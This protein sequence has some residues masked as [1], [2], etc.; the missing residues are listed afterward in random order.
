MKSALDRVAKAAVNF[1]FRFDYEAPFM[2]DRQPLSANVA[3]LTDG[4][5]LCNQRVFARAIGYVGNAYVWAPDKISLDAPCPTGIKDPIVRLPKGFKTDSYNLIR[6]QVQSGV[7]EA[8]NEQ[9]GMVANALAN[10]AQGFGLSAGPGGISE[11]E[12]DDI[13]LTLGGVVVEAT[14]DYFAHAMLGDEI[15]DQ[16]VHM[17]FQSGMNLTGSDGGGIPIQNL[18]EAVVRLP[19]YTYLNAKAAI[20]SAHK[21]NSDVLVYN[22]GIGCGFFAGNYSANVKK[23]N[24]EAVVKALETFQQEGHSLEVIVPNIGYVSDQE[25]RLEALGVRIIPADKDAVAALCAR[26]GLVVSV[27]VAADPMSMLGIHGPGL[28]WETAG[29]ASDEERA[30]YLSPCYGIAHTPILIYEEG[31]EDPIKVAALSEFMVIDPAE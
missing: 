19:Q 23:A 22:I 12:A 26:A 24:V 17:I 3:P 20:E 2:Q 18:R 31:C 1:P 6:R 4:S 14:V 10:V 30:A 29:S 21:N 11:Q 8:I 16:P 15:P 27:S 5:M 9:R 13:A 25:T 28:W 7:V